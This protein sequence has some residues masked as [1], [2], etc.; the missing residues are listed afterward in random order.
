[1]FLYTYFQFIPLPSLVVLSRHLGLNG[2][3]RGLGKRRRQGT[4]A[5]I[6]H[7]NEIEREKACSLSNSPE[8]SSLERPFGTLDTSTPAPSWLGAP[9]FGAPQLR[10]RLICAP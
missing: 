1:L 9:D 10:V 4:I 6:G 2:I 7:A 5:K 8:R 3:F